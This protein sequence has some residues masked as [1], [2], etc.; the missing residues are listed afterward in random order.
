[1]HLSKALLS[2]FALVGFASA[3]PNPLPMAGAITSPV[4][5]SPSLCKMGSTYFILTGGVGIPIYTSTDLVN[6]SAAGKVW[7]NGASWTDQYTGGSNLK[8]WA[9][10]CKVVNGVMHVYYCASTIGS[11]NSAIFYA[12]STTGASG[13]F[14][15]G[16][17]VIA[18]SNSN[19]YNAIDP[20]LSTDPVNY[21]TFGS[22]WTGIYGIQINPTTMLPVAGATLDHLAQRTNGAAPAGGAA[23]EEAPVIMKYGNWWYLFTSW[24]SD[25]EY[26]QV[27][28]ARS[29]AH[30][31][32]YAGSAGL[33]ALT[34]G[35]GLILDRHD[36]VLG[37]GGQDTFVNDN[38]DVYLVY[39]YKIGSPGALKFQIGL[40]RMNMSSGWPVV[41]VN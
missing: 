30:N 28:V 5:G 19:N 36:A 7:P 11:Q 15:N 20:S 39:H 33:S 2:V 24:N 18:T 26:Y 23:S 22:Y 10:D 14:T 4:G 40:N 41:G 13:S 31:G 29:S 38:G 27:R 12:R 34:N 9:P 17:L 3:Y 1:M 8:L 6:W 32:G 16:G 25:N 37:P 35:G 21:L